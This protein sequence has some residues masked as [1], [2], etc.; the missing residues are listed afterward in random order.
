M[1]ET[2]D[3]N[4]DE[5][6]GNETNI[7]PYILEGL[8]ELGLGDTTNGGSDVPAESSEETQPT[9]GEASQ[10]QA[11]KNKERFATRFSKKSKEAEEARMA[12]AK[13]EVERERFRQEAEAER[14]KAA[15]IQEQRD[16]AEA[17][18][19]ALRE[20][21]QS[22]QGQPDDY[23]YG[24]ENDDGYGINP[25]ARQVHPQGMR[26]DQV[27]EIVAKRLAAQ[28]E[29]AERRARVEQAK[30]ATRRDFDNSTSDVQRR[31]PDL[32]IEL[33]QAV[34]KTLE[35]ASTF[36][37]IG[38][39]LPF[40]S[41]LKHASETLRIIRKNPRF[42]HMTP[43]ELVSA[44]TEASTIIGIRKAQLAEP[45]KASVTKPLGGP[46]TTSKQSSSSSFE[47][48]HRQQ[49]EAIKKARGIK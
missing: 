1:N 10:P 25:P 41:K 20:R 7:N 11:S 38:A 42:Y 30:Q 27:E 45:G 3:W 47:E 17:E 15:L 39:A 16:R 24:F 35:E 48:F 46:A 28:A 4:D 44:A 6:Q 18:L 26:P 31:S 21:S 32:A 37:N 9:S 23:G 5:S 14:K 13:A 19:R 2:N 34:E 36:D 29:A 43:Q 49:N 33:N 8:E 40:I 12:A 22:L